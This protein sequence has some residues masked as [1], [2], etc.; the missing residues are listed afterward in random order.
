MVI[1]YFFAFILEQE[2][3]W[4]LMGRWIFLHASIPF[5]LRAVRI[6]SHQNLKCFW[7]CLSHFKAFDF[8][9][10]LVFH[11]YSF[12]KVEEGKSSTSGNLEYRSFKIF[13]TEH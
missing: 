1:T 2:G 8:G 6:L 9:H 5:E 13:R 3:I 7:I 10:M 4:K 11:K 12:N